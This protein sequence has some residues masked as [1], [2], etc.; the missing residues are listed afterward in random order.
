DHGVARRT[1]AI[2]EGETVPTNVERFAGLALM[3]GPMSA[4]DDLPWNAPLLELLRRAVA[5]DVP[6]LG[7]CLGGQ[8]L[9]K[10]LGAEVTWT[11]R[12]EIGWGEVRATKTADARNW[13]GERESFTTF[14]WHYEIFGLPKGATRILT[15]D[16]NP[17]QAYALGKHVGFQSHIEMTRAMVETW[18]RVGAAELP[19]NTRGAMQSRGDIVADI[20]DRLA[21]LGRV[22]DDVYRRWT[23][24]LVRQ[25][26]PV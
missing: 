15:N 17:E 3:G 16:E 23:R 12:P 25:D 7:H 2:D 13:F 11:A 10:A 22:A 5:G 14:Q 18:C 24:A 1:I 21:A 20:D 9:A 6:V 26:A 4:N 8:L 19:A